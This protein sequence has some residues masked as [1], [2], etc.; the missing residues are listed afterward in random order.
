MERTNKRRLTVVLNHTNDSASDT[1]HQ[2][3]LCGSKLTVNVT[4]TVSGP[5]ERVVTWYPETPWDSILGMFYYCMLF[6]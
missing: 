1:G 4:A 6:R 5:D 2:H 3:G